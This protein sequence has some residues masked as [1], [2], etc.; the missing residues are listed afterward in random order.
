MQTS[1]M[2]LSDAG[3]GSIIFKIKDYKGNLMCV[4][5]DRVL[6]LEQLSYFLFSPR[7]TIRQS[8]NPP[9]RFHVHRDASKLIFNAC[10][11]IA[12]HDLQ[13]NRPTLFSE[14]GIEKLHALFNNNYSIFQD[15]GLKYN[16]TH[17][18]RQLL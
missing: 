4:Q 5:I 2:R 6:R 12:H 7:Q 8:H 9:D 18:Q 11:K 13:K 17:G 10:T 3:V 16:L 1:K 15:D 14:S